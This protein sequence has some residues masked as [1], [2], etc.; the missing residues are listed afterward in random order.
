MCYSTRVEECRLVDTGASWPCL[1]DQNGNCST[2]VCHCLTTAA[3]RSFYPRRA[4]GSR[5]AVPIRRTHHGPA[6]SVPE[7]RQRVAWGVSPRRRSALKR[8]APKGRQECE[9]FVPLLSPLRGLVVLRSRSL[10]LTPQAT[11]CRR[12]AAEF[13]RPVGS[14]RVKR[15]TGN[16]PSV[17][18]RRHRREPAST[19]PE[20]RRRVAWGVSPR[21]RSALKREAPEGRQECESFVSLLSP[22]RGLVVLRS[23]SL[24]LTP[25]ATRCRR[26]AA[27]FHRAVASN[28]VKRAT[29]N[30]QAVPIRRRRREPASAR[31]S[32]LPSGFSRP[33][34][35][36]Q[37]ELVVAGDP[38][39]HQPGFSRLLVRFQRSARCGSLKT[40]REARLKPA[41]RVRRPSLPPA[42][43]GGKRRSA[44]GRP[45]GVAGLERPIRQIRPRNCHCLTD[46]VGPRPGGTIEGFSR[47]FGTR[48]PGGPA[49]RR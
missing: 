32:R 16:R 24:G 38:S 41:D 36:R 15:A 9:S 43:A 42:E 31:T 44:E 29:G 26:S 30:R 3:V 13:H 6:S 34:V 14:N 23:R 5:Q 46:A 18:I 11:R 21:R 45:G 7:G 12:S 4:D 47:P 49:S 22:L 8:E 28:R 17:P 1:M 20:G 27:E 40:S 10:G 39:P 25:Q 33:S 35:C 19:V 48:I 37:L 2:G